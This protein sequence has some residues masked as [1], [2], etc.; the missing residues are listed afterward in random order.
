MRSKDLFL[1]VL[2]A[3]KSMILGLASCEGFSL[4]WPT[5]EGKRAG[6]HTH[7]HTHTQR[8]EGNQTHPFARNILLP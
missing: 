5:V 8:R 4:H 6:K 1:I 2:G 7:T 3:G